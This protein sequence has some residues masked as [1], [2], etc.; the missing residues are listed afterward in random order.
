MPSKKFRNNLLMTSRIKNP[1]HQESSS[2]INFTKEEES[3]GKQ[4]FLETLLK[5]IMERYVMVYRKPTHTGQYVHYSSH[6]QKSGKVL[7]LSC[8]IDYIPS[9]PVKMI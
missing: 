1:S 6:H 5:R 7:F 8:L 4:E 3:N 9:S 2:N